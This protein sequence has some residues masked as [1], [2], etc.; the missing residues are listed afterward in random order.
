MA[1]RSQLPAV[2]PMRTKPTSLAHVQ[3]PLSQR[4]RVDAECKRLGWV[5]VPH[6]AGDDI[7]N[8]I[9]TNF[10][11]LQESLYQHGLYE[12]A[13][14]KLLSSIER[15]EDKLTEQL[16]G[17][18]NTWLRM[19]LAGWQKSA[20]FTGSISNG[21]LTTIGAVENTINPGAV[22]SGDT[23]ATGTVIISQLTGS[24]TGGAGTYAVSPSNQSVASA[25]LTATVILTNAVAVQMVD[26]LM[27]K[28]FS[29][30][31]QKIADY[32]LINDKDD[33]EALL[34]LDLENLQEDV[35]EG[36]VN[37]VRG[38]K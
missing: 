18:A 2:I 20:T 17:I 32:R 30:L 10:D 4:W 36:V 3:Q 21:V 22:L 5:M 31:G 34:L 1:N 8:V 14:P 38:W 7:T 6:T 15:L 33:Q 27:S 11:K 29:S 24:V 37:I 9:A 13:H 25:P 26:E 16:C 35:R 19:R 28:L 23:V 12:I